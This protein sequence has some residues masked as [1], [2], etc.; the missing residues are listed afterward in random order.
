MYNEMMRSWLRIVLRPL[1]LPYIDDPDLAAQYSDDGLWVGVKGPV[2]A[3]GVQYVPGDVWRNLFSWKAYTR[4][5]R[6]EV[7]VHQVA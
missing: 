7:L 1:A 4:R 3:P 2:A 6:H 5:R